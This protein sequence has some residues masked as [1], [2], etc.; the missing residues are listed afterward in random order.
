MSDLAIHSATRGLIVPQ[1][2]LPV[3]IRQAT[4]DD[5]PFIDELQKL[6]NKMLGFMPLAQL[7]G[8][9][10]SGNVL[11][12][13][14]G[15]CG[16][17]ARTNDPGALGAC[18]GGTPAL[19]N[20]LGYIIA[21]DKYFKHED[22]GIIYQLNVAPGSQR[23][24]VGAA[25]VKA[26]FDR[27]AYGCRLFCCWCAQDIEANWFWESI[28]F[29]PLAF[30]TGSREARRMAGGTPA[31]PGPRIHIFWQRRIR[32]GDAETPYWYPSQTNAGAIRE[33]RLVLPIPPGTHWSDAK[34]TILPTAGAGGSPEA[35]GVRSLPP[36]K[37]W[38]RQGEPTEVRRLRAM[39][40]IRLGGLRF[41]PAQQAAAPR[42]QSKP[43]PGAGRN[44]LRF[45]KAKRRNDPQHV[46][47]ARELRDRYLEEMNS[48]RLLPAAN[49]KYDISRQLAPGLAPAKLVA[50]ETP[51]PLP[52][53]AA[54]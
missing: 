21:R 45:E 10:E 42:A 18:A 32:E 16:R 39:K 54:A 27:A 19:P 51:A 23:K 3:S 13:E 48:G 34:P 33:D 22:V 25:L 12:A 37:E 7:Q 28:G 5:L 20:P 17:P 6:H 44:G 4:M 8:Y 31:P 47:M 24:L 49:A 11:I 50:G 29:V 14:D 43:D 15:E 26:V 30:R 40:S 2:R 9:V 38:K 35:A 1:A 36:A 53:L 52:M 41:A 46:A